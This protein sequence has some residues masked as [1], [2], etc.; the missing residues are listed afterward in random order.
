MLYSRNRNMYAPFCMKDSQ[1][2]KSVS[3]D[4][5]LVGQRTALRVLARLFFITITAVGISNLVAA[6]DH[7]SLHQQVLAVYDFAPHTLSFTAA[8]FGII[9]ADSG[10]VV[11]T[12]AVLL[13]L[14]AGE[15]RRMSG[16][17]I[18]AILFHALKRGVRREAPTEA[19]V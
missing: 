10:I 6:A 8:L 3:G 2:R 18:P 16:R 13:G 11:A 14:I 1:A 4:N 9:H 7:V 15:L 19:G 5:S 17:L 12:E